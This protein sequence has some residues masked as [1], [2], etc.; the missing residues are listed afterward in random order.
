MRWCR[1]EANKK[2]TYGIVEGDS[3]QPVAGSPFT[4]YRRNGTPLPLN[5]VTLLIP[6]FPPTFYAAG[7]LNYRDHVLNLKAILGREGQMPTEADIGYR[8]QSA[9][10]ATDQPIRIP[11]DASDRI[12]Y[13]GE[14]VAVIGKEGKHISR[15]RV[16]E[17]ILGYTI[18][19]DFTD[20][21][22]QTAGRNTWRSKN[23]DTFKPLG[24]WIETD[25]DIDA[26]QTKVRVNGK[27]L[28]NFK[29]GAML[30]GV[31]DFITTLTEYATIK[32]GDIITMGTDGVPKNV[33]HGDIIEIEITGIGTLRNQVLRE[34]V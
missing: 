18:C 33:K 20:R 32:P 8:A 21:V 15:D 25:F 34:E 2:A 22:W 4:K 14:L 3:V 16:N 6:V 7:N 1:F 23:A 28:E 11:R 29:T 10:V 24:P 30:F 9:L 12:Q 17:Y 19:N 26:A 27:E 5:A 31:A 13:E